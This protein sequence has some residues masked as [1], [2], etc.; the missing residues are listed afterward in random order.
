MAMRSLDGADV[1]TALQEV[2][3]VAMAEM[4]GG[5][6]SIE[7]EALDLMPTALAVLVVAESVGAV[8]IGQLWR[9]Q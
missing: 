3:G 5:Q 4:V 1:S 2:R 9:S 6:G 8:V 7:P